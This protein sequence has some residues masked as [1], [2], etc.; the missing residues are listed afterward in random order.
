MLGLRALPLRYRM[1]LIHGGTELIATTRKQAWPLGDTLMGLKSGTLVVSGF[2]SESLGIGRAGDLTANALEAAGYQIIRHNLRPCFKHIVDQ[3]AKLVDTNGGV[4]LIHANAPESLIALMSH[5]PDQ[6]S[7]RYRIGYWAWETPL[8]PPSWVRM[9]KYFHEIWV[10]SHFVYEALKAGFA[11]RGASDLT[12][13]L[14]IMPHPL[15]KKPSRPDR[16]RFGLKDNA[17]QALSLFD[18][19]SSITRK[20]PWSALE[21]W[22]KA[23]PSPTERARLTLKVQ[24]LVKDDATQNRLG[25]ILKDR[26]DIRLFSEP[27]SDLEMNRFMASFDVLISLHRSEG[28][29]LSLLEAMAAGVT[30]IATNWSGNSDFVREDNAIP[31]PYELV[32]ICDPEGNYFGL[33]HDRRQYWAEPDIQAAADALRQIVYEPGLREKLAE[34][35]RKTPSRLN[36][37]WQARALTN[38]PFNQFL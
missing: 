29:G 38:L 23:F 27:L 37:V 4:W 35:A 17:I 5:S 21:A 22:L 24:N 14:R 2:F 10:P 36:E 31:V 16:T 32:P 28:F 26:P 7:A 13:R 19:N 12:P 20:N 11:A 9:A 8:A 34:V 33:S 15:L 30:V 1:P 3:K 25:A 6:W 18:V